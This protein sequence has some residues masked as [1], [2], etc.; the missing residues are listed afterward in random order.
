M[1]TGRLGGLSYAAP[2]LTIWDDSGLTDREQALWVAKGRVGGID[3][4][5]IRAREPDVVAAVLVPASWS[6]TEDKA[7]VEWL[8]K[9]YALA[10]KFPQGNYGEFHIWIR[11][12]RQSQ[13]YK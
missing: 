9:E 8:E 4:N 7:Y 13:I 3:A 1:Q 6:Y 12:E 5:P 10:S 2:E 11:K